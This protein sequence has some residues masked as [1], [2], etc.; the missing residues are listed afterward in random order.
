MR[1]D[2]TYDAA[3][4]AWTKQVR[5]IDFLEAR[6]IWQDP[7]AAQGPGNSEMGE[8]RWLI[9]GMAMGRIWTACF[10]NRPAGVRIISVRPARDI[11]KEV[12]Y[13]Y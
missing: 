9:I 12:Y 13:G 1:F 3:K 10:T 11:E 2:E 7:N 6:E 5:G 4:S 8:D